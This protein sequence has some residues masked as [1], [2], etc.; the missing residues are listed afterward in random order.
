MGSM[1]ENQGMTE[2]VIEHLF[3]K[4]IP[5]VLCNIGGSDKSSKFIMETVM[6]KLTKDQK[7]KDGTITK[8]K[9]SDRVYG[10]DWINLGYVMVLGWPS[11]N[12]FT[13]DMSALY[14]TDYYKN[15]TRDYKKLPIMK[16]TK[17]EIDPKT[18]KPIRSINIDDVYMAFVVTYSPCED[19]IP[20]VHGV[21]NTPLAFGCAGI[22]SSTK[23]R[24]LTSGQLKGLLVSVRGGA[25]YDVLLNPDKPAERTTLATTLIAPLAYGHLV[26]IFAIILGNIGYFAGRRRRS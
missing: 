25:E 14:P 16:P 13:K 24:F 17:A 19:W 18:E 5:F 26:I 10:K 11:L 9:Y 22:E 2:A 1:A 12:V 3:R 23:Y 15:D 21:Y 8:A 7:N 4:R 20:F 6:A